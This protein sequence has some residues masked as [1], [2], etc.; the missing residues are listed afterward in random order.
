MDF[1]ARILY[2]RGPQFTVST[3]DISCSVAVSHKCIHFII[4]ISLYRVKTDFTLDLVGEQTYEYA[5]M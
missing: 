1:S 2:V 3:K 5:V 4:I